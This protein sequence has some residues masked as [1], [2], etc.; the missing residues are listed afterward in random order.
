MILVDT[1]LLLYAVNRDLSQH[2][3]AREWWESVLSRNIP[4]AIAWIVILAFLRI[5]TNPRIFEHPLG[6]DSAMAYI[7]EWLAV[8]CVQSI[9]PGYGHRQILRQLITRSGTGGNLT[10]DAHLAALAIE[11]GYTL[12]SADNDFRRFAGL[13]HINPLTIE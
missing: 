7:D 9:A 1:N 12:Y 2:D 5:S 6:I 3:A 11:Q 10:A 8:P 13:V 4:V